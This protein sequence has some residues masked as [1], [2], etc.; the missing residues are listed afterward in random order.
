MWRI[1]YRNL[2]FLFFKPFFNSLSR[3]WSQPRKKAQ[4]LLALL[5]GN[6]TLKKVGFTSR[7]NVVHLNLKVILQI[8]NVL[9]WKSQFFYFIF[10]VSFDLENLLSRIRNTAFCLHI[11]LTRWCLLR[12]LLDDERLVVLEL[13]LPELC[14]QGVAVL[15][16]V[17][18]MDALYLINQIKVEQYWKTDRVLGFKMP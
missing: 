14:L 3:S 2:Y 4:L 7:K 5:A 9:E 11:F 12:H 13:A 1:R 18:K 8:F 10:Q 17:Q 15:V 6:F 16:L